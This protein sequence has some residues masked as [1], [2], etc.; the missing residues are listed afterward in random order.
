MVGAPGFEP[1]TSSSR[2]KRATRL[3]YAPISVWL[4]QR[5]CPERGALPNCATP[6]F[7]CGYINVSVPNEARYRAALRPDVPCS[8]INV[9][10]LGSRH[11]CGGGLATGGPRL[12]RWQPLLC[13]S[14]PRPHALPARCRGGR[15]KGR[16]DPGRGSGAAPAVG[17]DSLS[18]HAT[19]TRRSGCYASF[20]GAPCRAPG[21]P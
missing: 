2:T 11:R 4:C 12:G 1:G 20:G 3:R 15:R 18:G 7:P 17:E 21:L 16:E 5:Q 8:Y 13:R 6:R 9:S 14:L 10:V 19:G